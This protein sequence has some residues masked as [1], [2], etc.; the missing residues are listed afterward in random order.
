MRASGHAALLLIVPGGRGG[1]DRY[2]L[3]RAGTRVCR[4]RLTPLARVFQRAVLGDTSPA[5][6][7]RGPAF[8]GIKSAGR[9]RVRATGNLELV[10]HGPDGYTPFREEAVRAG[11]APAVQ[12]A[13][14]SMAATMLPLR[15]AGPPA[16]SAW[17]D[18]YEPS[19]IRVKA[20]AS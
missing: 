9:A 16:P 13:G 12:L 19:K 1:L 20:S 15:R 7:A 17:A 3:A 14:S 11:S 4:V 2:A 10:L 6:A 18:A 5:A 8:E